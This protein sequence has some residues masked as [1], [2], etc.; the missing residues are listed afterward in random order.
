MRWRWAPSSSARRT[1][2]T[3]FQRAAARAWQAAAGAVTSG[4]KRPGGRLCSSVSRSRSRE[5]GW[6]PSEQSLLNP[7][8]Q[9]TTL[10]RSYLI[11]SCLVM[12]SQSRCYLCIFCSVADEASWRR[13]KWP[14]LPTGLQG[15]RML[16]FFC[17]FYLTSLRVN[18]L[19]RLGS[20]TP[21]PIQIHTE[22]YQR[23]NMEANFYVDILKKQLNY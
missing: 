1:T 14:F 17:W 11:G 19:W 3:L 22:R 20:G 4:C 23:N 15:F 8:P 13:G 2:S 21:Q 16:D 18:S 5:S 12:D 10:V 7:W 6:K 9:R